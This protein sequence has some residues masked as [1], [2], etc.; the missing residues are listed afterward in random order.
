M[1][2][3]FW[4]DKTVKTVVVVSLVA[5]LLFLG[6]CGVNKQELQTRVKASLQTELSAHKLFKELKPEVTSLILTQSNGNRFEG[7]S[8]IQLTKPDGT[9][10]KEYRLKVSVT[11]DSNSM[12]WEVSPEDLQGLLSQYLLDL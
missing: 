1:L 9:R 2:P 12:Q 6:G 8:M 11:A 10:T 3:I 7:L 4:R 5:F